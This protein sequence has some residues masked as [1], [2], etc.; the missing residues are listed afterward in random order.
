M[1]SSSDIGLEG[2][3][4]ELVSLQKLNHVNIIRFMGAVYSETPLT[5][6]I[7]LEYCSGGDLQ[8]ALSGITPPN[9]FT[10]VA[11]DVANGM[12][13]LH[14]VKHIMH[15]DIKVCLVLEDWSSCTVY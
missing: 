15:R 8:V 2:W 7:V 5:Y 14:N 4:A 9:L 3:K 10:K 11:T 6:M 1:A 13:Y 12:Y